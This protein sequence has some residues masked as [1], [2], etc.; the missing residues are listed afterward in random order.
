MFCDE[1]HGEIV[2]SRVHRHSD[3]PLVVRLNTGQT[4]AVT[5]A[6][7]RVTDIVSRSDAVIARGKDI[8]AT[9]DQQEKLAMMA[10][11]V[12]LLRAGVCVCGGGAGGRARP[13]PPPPTIVCMHTRAYITPPRTHTHTHTHTSHT[14]IHTRTHT[15]T[16]TRTHTRWWR[17]REAL[18]VELRETLTT[19]ESSAFGLC[20]TFFLGL[21][22]SDT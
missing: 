4:H 14:H 20:K 7:E 16:H 2:L 3:E 11:Y 12:P 17:D 6:R 5:T 15:H 10:T 13:P 21:P 1:E 9:E 19:L 22:V 18:D 8:V